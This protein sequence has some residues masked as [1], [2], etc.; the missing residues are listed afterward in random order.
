MQPA[1]GST[2]HAHSGGEEQLGKGE[3]L[4]PITPGTPS[5]GCRGNSSCQLK[6][7]LASRKCRSRLCSQ[8]G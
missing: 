2:S 7:E 6:G 3:E 5:C 1:T 4:L 8:E